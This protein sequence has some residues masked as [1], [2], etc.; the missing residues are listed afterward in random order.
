MALTLSMATFDTMPK[1]IRTEGLICTTYAG[2]TDQCQ[3]DKTRLSGE[4]ENETWNVFFVVVLPQRSCD[5]T[6]PTPEIGEY[7]MGLC[8]SKTAGQ[9]VERRKSIDVSLHLTDTDHGVARNWLTKRP[10]YNCTRRQFYFA[11]PQPQSHIPR[12]QAV[13]GTPTYPKPFNCRGFVP[14][15]VSL[16]SA[17]S[18]GSMPAFRLFSQSRVPAVRNSGRHDDTVN[19][20]VLQSKCCIHLW[21]K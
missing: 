2:K 8:A 1:S 16:A 10:L 9:Q 13:C 17:S 20:V 18:L 3:T 14:A 4:N 7:F 12:N 11:T 6:E 5:D 21:V 19:D 15:R